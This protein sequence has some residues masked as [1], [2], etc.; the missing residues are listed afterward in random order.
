MLQLLYRQ[1][2]DAHKK[3]M[4]N[5]RII[6]GWAIESNSLITKYLNEGGSLQMIARLSKRAYIR[7]RF[8]A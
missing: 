1:M 2:I 4:A 8:K 6:Y 3:A 7:A 5:D